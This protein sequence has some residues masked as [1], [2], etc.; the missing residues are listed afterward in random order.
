MAHND[1]NLADR[2]GNLVESYKNYDPRIVLFYFI[3]AA[4]LVTLA[5]GLGYQQVHLTGQHEERERLQTQRRILIPGPRGNIYDRNGN[6]L[7]TNSPRWT[8]V[9]HLEELNKEFINESERIRKNYAA[10]MQQEKLSPKD[11][12][13]RVE[14]RQIACVTVAQR[15][16]DEVSKI[17]KR[18]LRVD[19]KELTNHFRK[20]LLLPFTLVDDLNDQDYA[21]LIERLPVNSPLQVYATNIRSYPYK[22]AA[23]HTL[24]YV[25]ADSEVEAEDFPGE[26]LKT[27]SMKNTAGVLGLEKVF[28]ERLRGIPGG[29]IYRVNPSGYK[30]KQPIEQRKPEK[31]ADLVTSLDIDLQLAAE[32]AIGDRTGAAIALDVNTGEVL[33]M[34]SK[35]DYNLNDFYPHLSSETY[36]AIQEKGAELNFAV[37]AR[38]PPGSTFKILTSIAGLRRGILKPDESIVDCNGTLIRGTGRYVCYNG[39]GHHHEVL[40]PQAIAESCDIYFYQAGWNITPTEISNEGRRFHL[41][42]A[43]GIESPNDNGRNFILPD[44]A[45]KRKAKNE[46]WYPGDTANMAIGQGFVLLSPLQM[47]CF[48]ASVARN[49][50]V[51]HPTLVHE[52]NRPRQHSEPIGLTPGQRAALLEGMVGCTL[53][54]KGTARALTELAALRIPGVRVAGKTGTAQKDV[55]RDG[56][57]GKINYA[58]FICFA[59]AENPEIAMAVVLEGE[60]VGEEYGGGRESAPVAGIVMKKYFEKKANPTNALLSPLKT[61]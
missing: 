39:I 56:K 5:V 11:L 30:V 60:N 14:R 34:A 61:K 17:L 35:P 3:I 21:K 27:F 36:R 7:V 28:D 45:W 53:P 20:E 43:T 25:R 46:T 40:L 1:V 41:D 6:V 15:Y 16:L 18:P 47:A 55:N 32:E 42:Q 29:A 51:T 52:S 44:E 48:A 26:G 31:G 54:P 33:V 12:P 50:T 22:S 19:S 9:L 10:L 37:S 24:G 57:S 49:E 2:P 13:D 23:A 8:V 38:L 58:W 4:L 59:P